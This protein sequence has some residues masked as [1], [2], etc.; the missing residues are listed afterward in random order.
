[1]T[2]KSYPVNLFQTN[3][4]QRPKGRKNQGLKDNG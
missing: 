2:V 3:I 4:N 1:L